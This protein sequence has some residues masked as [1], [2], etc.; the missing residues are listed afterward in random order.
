MTNI[1]DEFADPESVLIWA[2]DGSLHVRV[3][4]EFYGANL[5]S[6]ISLTLNKQNRARLRAALDEIDSM[7]SA[8]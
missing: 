1:N 6:A 4:S 2:D 8:K 5:S 3:S 7:E